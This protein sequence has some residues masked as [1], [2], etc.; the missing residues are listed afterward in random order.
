MKAYEW[1]LVDKLKAP[2]NQSWEHFYLCEIAK[3]ILWVQGY[4]LIAGEIYVG[5]DAKISAEMGMRNKYYNVIDAL[6]IN[7][8]TRKVKGI[9]VKV[10]LDDFRSGYCAVVP[11]TSILCPRDVVPVS[12]IPQGIGLIYADIDKIKVRKSDSCLDVEGIETVKKARSR[13]TKITDEQGQIK[14]REFDYM[15]SGAAYGATVR[16]IYKNPWVDVYEKIWKNQSWI[17][18]EAYNTIDQGEVEPCES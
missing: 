18:A 11:N 6:G 17:R 9:E 3:F 10:S 12:L 2:K 7:T 14:T 8:R 16:T 15:V 1:I 5:W 4:N 13:K